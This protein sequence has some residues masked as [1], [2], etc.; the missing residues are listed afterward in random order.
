MYDAGK[1]M[2]IHQFFCTASNYSVTT[3][4]Y[5]ILFLERRLYL[6]LNQPR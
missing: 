5:L 6:Y 4:F 2:Q 1:V 3:G